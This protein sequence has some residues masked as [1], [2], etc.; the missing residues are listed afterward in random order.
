MERAH[1]Y[2]EL[3]GPQP[4]ETVEAANRLLAFIERDTYLDARL[5]GAPPKTAYRAACVALIDAMREID[6][7]MLRNAY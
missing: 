6:A 3:C 2:P 5:W 4:R 1:F 7:R